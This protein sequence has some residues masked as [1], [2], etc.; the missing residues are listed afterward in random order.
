MFDR[1]QVSGQDSLV[2]AGLLRAWQPGQHEGLGPRQGLRGGH[3]ADVAAGRAR[4]LRPRH[5][6]DALSQGVC[7]GGLQIHWKAN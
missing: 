2:P 3:V 1:F 7:R 6:D 4:R 5:G